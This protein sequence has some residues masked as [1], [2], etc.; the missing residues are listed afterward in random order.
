MPPCD[1]LDCAHLHNEGFPRGLLS[2]RGPPA[3]P[4][5][6]GI[7]ILVS[8]YVV[9]FWQKIVVTVTRYFSSRVLKTFP[10][11]LVIVTCY[12]MSFALRSAAIARLIL[13]ASL[14]HCTRVETGSLAVVLSRIL[15]TCSLAVVPWVLLLQ[16]LFVAGYDSVVLFW[17]PPQ[18]LLSVASFVID[19]SAGALD[20]NGR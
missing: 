4:T 18:S 15:T 6:L 2:P 16:S 3:R 13:D 14:L 9:W 17:L 19:G 7:S 11:F 1:T 10:R 8:L 12:A 5:M 20:R